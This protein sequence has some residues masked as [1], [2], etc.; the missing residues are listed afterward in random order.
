MIAVIFVHGISVRSAGYER[1][2]SQV[3]G[4]LERNAGVS[5][6]PCLWGDSH[7]ARLLANGASIPRYNQTKGPEGELGELQAEDRWELLSEDP[8]LELRLLALR[9]TGPVSEFDPRGSKSPIQQLGERLRTFTPSD[10]LFAQLSQA[11]IPATAL[12]GA[13]KRVVDDPVLDLALLASGEDLGEFRHAWARAVIATA[14]VET[15]ATTLDI[16]AANLQMLS[17]QATALASE[18]GNQSKGA[19][20]DW[21]NQ[22]LASVGTQ[23]IGNRRGRYIDMLVPYVGDVLVYQGNGQRIRDLISKRID[24]VPEGTPVVLLGHSLGGI[25]CVD[26]LADAA[27]STVKLL[28]TVGSQSP[29]FY[30]LNALHNLRFGQTLPAH[31]PRWL[32]IYDQRDFLSYVAEPIFKDGC[33]TGVKDDRVTDIKV[34][35]RQPFP[36]SHSAYWANPKVWDI[37]S[38]RLAEVGR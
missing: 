24:S 14:L 19:L 7:G 12:E 6:L 26:L 23:L 18:L 4:A 16:S 33:G 28:V 25:A 5:V 36:Y 27:H 22:A 8:L 34:S 29:L 11:G 10:T 38:Q 9:P 35:N 30:E 37:I 31:F 17:M 15:A 32:N 21:L 20:G 2:L 3:K 13:C 1:S